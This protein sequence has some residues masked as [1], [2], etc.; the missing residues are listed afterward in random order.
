MYDSSSDS[1]YRRRQGL[2]RLTCSR[3]KL[4]CVPEGNSSYQER[5]ALHKPAFRSSPPNLR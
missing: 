5:P 4:V 1:V 3:Q 2:Q